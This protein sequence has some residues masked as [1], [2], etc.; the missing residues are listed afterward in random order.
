MRLETL[1]AKADKKAPGAKK[2]NKCA[3]VLSGSFGLPLLFIEKSVKPWTL[4]ITF[5]HHQ[6]CIK[7][8]KVLGWMFT[9]FKIGF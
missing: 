6:L 5:F 2:C 3:T 8:K 1:T 7:I 4:I 9:F